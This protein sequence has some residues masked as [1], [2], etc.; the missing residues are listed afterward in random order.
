MVGYAIDF[1]TY[2]NM[3]NFIRVEGAPFHQTNKKTV[4]KQAWAVPIQIHWVESK[5]FQMVGYAHKNDGF[6]ADGIYLMNY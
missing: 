1:P 4:D 5:F 3:E 2:A 6:W